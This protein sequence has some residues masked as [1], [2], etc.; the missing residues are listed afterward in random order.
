MVLR[1]PEKCG[2]RRK[3]QW[4]VVEYSRKDRTVMDLS[5]NNEN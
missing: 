1:E 5:A 2:V 3:R 4:D